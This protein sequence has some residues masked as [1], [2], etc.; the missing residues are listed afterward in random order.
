MAFDPLPQILSF[1]SWRLFLEKKKKLGEK[2][3]SAAG[4]STGFCPK[5]PKLAIMF[6]LLTPLQPHHEKKN[7]DPPQQKN[8]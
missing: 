4:A 3:I 8:L 1:L 5:R 6:L 2:T 7:Y